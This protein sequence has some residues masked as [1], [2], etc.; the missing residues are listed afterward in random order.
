MQ[1]VLILDA[2]NGLHLGMILILQ[3]VLLFMIQISTTS[4]I[5]K[6]YSKE[7]PSKYCHRR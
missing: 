2:K 4:I 3:L 7:Y 6:E 1:K 5:K